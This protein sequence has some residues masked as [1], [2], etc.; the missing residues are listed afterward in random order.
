[1]NIHGSLLVSLNR[2]ETQGGQMP[3][4]ARRIAIAVALLSTLGIS[5]G[6]VTPDA[7]LTQ[8]I[9]EKSLS[10]RYAIEAGQAAID[11][12]SANH[13]RAIAV[14][15][16]AR[17]NTRLQMVGDRGNYNLLDEARRKARTAALMRRSTT[18]IQ[19]ALAA[20][21]TMRIPPDPD[22]LVIPGGVPFSAG[23]EI[24][25]AIGIAGGSPELLNNCAQAG[26][27]K[28]KEYLHP[29]EPRANASRAGASNPGTQH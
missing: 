21:P 17:G 25:G 24:V 5:N 20:N 13:L 1:M 22:F 19:Q 11:A 9:T 7:V 10:L 29:E 2:R 26:V 23:S 18:A 12:C 3:K 27:D 28:L 15:V 6:Q 16:D 14:I 4:L 8:V